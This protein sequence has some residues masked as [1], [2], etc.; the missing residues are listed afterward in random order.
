M[1][2]AKIY[3]YNRKKYSIEDNIDLEKPF[4]IEVDGQI[5]KNA[6]GVICRY[7]TYENAENSLITYANKKLKEIAEM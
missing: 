4:V 1:K 2:T 7:K 6:S 3:K 5:L